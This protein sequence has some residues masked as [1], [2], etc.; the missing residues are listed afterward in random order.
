MKMKV[1]EILKGE[2]RGIPGL[3]YPCKIKIYENYNYPKRQKME[4]TIFIE[5]CNTFLHDIKTI[6][7]YSQKKNISKINNNNKNQISV[8]KFFMKKNSENFAK[9]SV[10]NVLLENLPVIGD[11]TPKVKNK[12]AFKKI[13]EGS[14]FKRK[15][16]KMKTLNIEKDSFSNHRYRSFSSRK[17]CTTSNYQDSKC[18]NQ[19]RV[20]NLFNSVLKNKKNKK[21]LMQNS[22]EYILQNKIVVMNN[23]IGKLNKPIFICNKTN[24]N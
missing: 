21:P 1:G 19:I 22:L 14:L 16:N 20:E 24:I 5:N 17:R 8:K 10:P 2:I 15:I 13:D 3:H 23:M 9:F 4:N 6:R 11:S 7:S 12:T 18:I